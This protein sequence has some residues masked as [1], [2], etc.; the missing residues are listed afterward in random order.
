[1]SAFNKQVIMKHFLYF[2]LFLIFGF[3]VHS[4]Q[5]LKPYPFIFFSMAVVE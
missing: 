4:S 1:M 2:I 5:A 3:I